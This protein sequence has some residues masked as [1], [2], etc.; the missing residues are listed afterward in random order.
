MGYSTQNFAKAQTLQERHCLITSNSASATSR[1]APGAGSKDNS[2]PRPR[3][4]A[5]HYAN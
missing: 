1:A 4:H 5:N 3:Y 2:A